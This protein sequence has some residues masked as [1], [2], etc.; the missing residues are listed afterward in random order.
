MTGGLSFAELENREEGMT[1]TMM[2][3]SDIDKTALVPDR[4]AT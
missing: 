4:R 3:E 1:Y 2:I